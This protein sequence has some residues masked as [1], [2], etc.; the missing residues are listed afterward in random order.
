M[1]IFCNSFIGIEFTYR[2]SGPFKVCSS[3]VFS[4]FADHVQPS[5]QISE[6]CHHR[7]KK[8]HTLSSH[9]SEPPQPQPTA[10]LLSVPAA[11]P[12]PDI[13]HE[14]NRTH[15]AFGSWL[16]SP[17][18]FP[19]FLRVRACISPPFFSWLNTIPLYGQACSVYPLTVGA[20]STLG[21]WEQCECEHP[22]LR[23]RTSSLLLATPLGE[24]LPA[25]WELQLTF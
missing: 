19:R 7:K 9:P 18:T 10:G 6:H 20:A 21:R 11:L 23:A 25:P 14:W 13:A 2:I 12:F 3:V 1:D 17:S 4:V 24:G 5:Q 16:V 15:A 22:C 8:P